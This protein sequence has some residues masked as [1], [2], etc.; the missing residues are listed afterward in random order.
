M[1]L[2]FSADM[3]PPPVAGAFAEAR[4]LV[5]RERGA[6]A[7]VDQG[8]LSGGVKAVFE[9]PP[10]CTQQRVVH[11]AAAAHQPMRFVQAPGNRREAVCLRA[12]TDDSRARRASWR[13][14]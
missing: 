12:R 1:R 8:V 13:R 9:L 5:G 3:A 2:I 11:P 4:D 14:R 10:E 6:I 7:V